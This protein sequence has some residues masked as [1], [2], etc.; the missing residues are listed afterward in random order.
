MKSNLYKLLYL[1]ALI[2]SF[3][4]YSQVESKQTSSTQ[5][6]VEPDDCEYPTTWYFDNDKDG[7][8]DPNDYQLACTAPPGGYWVSNSNDCN[9]NDE[10]ITSGIWYLDNDKDGFGSPGNPMYGCS[11]PLNYVDNNLDCDD[12]NF[13]INPNTKWYLDINGDGIISDQDGTPIVRCTKPAGNY[14]SVTTDRNNHWIHEVSYD[15]KGKTIASSRTYFDNLAKPNVSLAKDFSWD[16]IWGTE[17][18]Y[19]NFGRSD[20]TSFIAPSPLGNFDKTNFLKNSAQIA[21]GSYPANLTINNITSNNDYKAT[22]SIT[23]TGTVSNGLTVSLTAPS[24]TLGNTFIVTATPGSSFTITAAILPDIS[25]NPTLTNYYS[26][27]NTYEPYQATA[28]HP[29]AQ[30]NYDLLNPKNI[31]NVVGGN[32]INGEWKTGYSYTIPAAQEMYYVYG[33]NYVND[34]R[35]VEPYISKKEYAPYN[36]IGLSAYYMRVVT[37]ETNVMPVASIPTAL[38]PN[39]MIPLGGIP[40]AVQANLPLERGKLYK[41]LIAG[42]TKIVQI[43]NEI[44]FRKANEFTNLVN[45]NNPVKVIAGYWDTYGE[46]DTLNKV[47]IIFNNTNNLITGLKCYKTISVDANGAEN[48]LFTDS[49]GKQLASARSGGEL[50][51]SVKSLIGPQGFVDIHL[52]VGCNGTVNFIGSSALYNVY[53]LKTGNLLTDAEK[54]TMPAGTYRIELI[55]KSNFSLG[56][57]YFDKT[58]G[59]IKNVLAE[60]SGVSYMVNYYDYAINVYNKTGQLIKSIQPNGYKANSSIVSTPGHMESTAEFVTKY[61]YNSLGQLIEANDPDQGISKFAYRKDGQIRYSQSALQANNNE[62]SYTNYDG[63]SRPIE[64]GVIVGSPGIWETALSNVDNNSTITGLNIKERTFSVYDYAENTVTDSVLLPTTYSLTIPTNLSLATLAPTYAST[65]NNLDSNVAITYKAD[66]G[67]AIN[68][69]TWYSY[70]IYGRTEWIAQYNE[71]IGVKTIHYEYDHNSQVTKVL[72]QKNTPEQFVHLYTYDINNGILTK[73]QTSTNNTNFTT[74]ADYSYYKTGELKRINIGEGTQGLDYVYTLGGQLKSINHP[75]LEAAK[76][77]G[78]DNNDV[79]GLTLDYYNGDYLRTGRN[80]TS[81]PTAGADY[82]GNIKAARWANKGAGDFNGS[83]ASQKGYLYTY[84]R[85]NWLT[86]ANYGGANSTTAAIAAT[87]SYKE[88]TLTYDPNGNILKMQRN[89]ASGNAQDDLNY[90][91]N[92]GKNQLNFVRDNVG[93]AVTNTA[94]IAN[95]N[96]GNYEYD[97][98]GQ[99]IKNSSENL[100]YIYNTQGLVVEVNKGST[101]VLVRF[102]YNERGQ[103][104]KKESYNPNSFTIQNTTFYE[105]DLSGN[106]IAVYNLPAGGNITQTELP[107]YGLSRL[108]IYNRLSDKSSYEITDHLGNVRAVV[109]KSG[110]VPDI[111][112]FAD[113]YPFGELFPGR[114]ASDNN[115][116]YA[117]QGQ[118]LDTDTNM[119][120]FQLRLWDGRIGRWLSTDPAGQYA[121][122][123]L[124][125]GNNPINGIDTNGGFWEELR[126]LFSGNGWSK[127]SQLYSKISKTNKISHS[128]YSSSVSDSGTKTLGTFYDANYVY[129]QVSINTML[130]SKRSD[131][132]HGYYRF[133]IPNNFGTWNE[134][135]SDGLYWVGCLSCHADNGAYRYAVYNSA[136][137]QIG[138]V[139]GGILSGALSR[140]MSFNV[141]RIN[142][143]PGEVMFDPD[144][145]KAAE[146]LGFYASDISVSNGTANIPITYSTKLNIKDMN[147][148]SERL[149]SLGVDKISIGSGPITNSKLA[150]FFDKLYQSGRTYQGLNVI[151]TNDP[152]NMFILEKNL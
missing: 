37:A 26:D 38:N 108:G 15:L 59:T 116:R 106:T 70:D 87:D 9:D 77:P 10:T 112:S 128:S 96:T 131:P 99:L 13:G 61:T 117:F 17:T 22:Q 102:S 83:T 52:P 133:I 135:G 25:A 57:T 45:I 35:D 80:I 130:V 145:A 60:D 109:Q 110:S 92:T 98:I 86:S 148:V 139:L 11:Q 132:S 47:S 66:S 144:A 39:V 34:N 91:Y 76:D 20:K 138:I 149:K 79:F 85:N 5:K 33:S 51:Y 69:I 28:T 97:A 36:N 123:Y 42:E 118:E 65:Q 84:N 12:G 115:Y 64:S 50:L 73:V 63:L 134:T 93:N 121:S 74:Q 56:L 21:A 41:M 82:N 49:D 72:F 18:T 143:A 114:N 147:I 136:E 151:K 1:I 89:N 53:N 68:A 141:P 27:N 54:G 24:I 43:F 90:N 140:T 8:G 62:V 127:D 129:E 105:L 40:Y 48:V 150:P 16:K 111:R 152:G 142:M 78:G 103:R 75:S 125:M 122:P 32:K 7:A 23:A 31:I 30:N 3:N 44:S 126:N 95:Q 107:I 81:S 71:G 6:I 137:R 120:A 55:N 19:D 88:G 29:F 100:N 104:I 14:Y 2:S 119:E 146:N 58:T 101:N 67:N 46:I 113:Y 4:T 124:G 94:D